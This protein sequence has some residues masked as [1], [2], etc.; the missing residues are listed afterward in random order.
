MKTTRNDAAAAAVHYTPT[1]TGQADCGSD[2][3]RVS[4]WASEVTCPDCH[5]PAPDPARITA[6]A[7]DRSRAQEQA[8]LLIDLRDFVLTHAWLPPVAWSV[9]RGYTAWC[10]LN[11]DQPDPAGGD[12]DPAGV[13]RAYS[14]A[15][16][17]PIEVE[18]VSQSF[19]IHRVQGRTGP[20][21][22]DEKPRT[23]LTVYLGVRAAG[24]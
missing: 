3:G 19:A 13:L 12:H 10:D 9:A 21:D 6:S 17:A 20:L 4:P 5:V 7:A 8:A 11:P 1:S 23:V 2:T 14:E 15:L 22:F 18:Q 24:S 16:R